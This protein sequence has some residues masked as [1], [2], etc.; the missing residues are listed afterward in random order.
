MLAVA[1]THA[2]PAYRDYVRE[3]LF[4][5]T[6]HRYAQSWNSHQPPWYFA[7]VIATLWLPTALLLPFAIGPWRRR[8]ARRDARYLLPLA[9]VGLVLL[10][11]SIPDGKRDV[12]IL[13]ALPMLCLALGPLLPGLVRRR[14]VR[15][16][17]FVFAALV[18][19][20]T[21]AA[22]LA[23]A[24]GE[25]AFERRLVAERGLVNG[26]EALAAA[27]VGVGL[28]GTLALAAGRLVHALPALAAT[29][30]SLWIA[31]GI[32]VAPL[33]N[34]AASGR[35][36]MTAVESRLGPGDELAL[37]AWKEQMLFM[38]ARP[39]QTFGFATR[40][41][42]QLARAMAWQA[43]K[44]ASRW[45][46]VQEAALTDCIDRRQSVSVGLANRRQWWLVPAAA[47][48]DPHC[49]IVG[50]ES[51]NEADGQDD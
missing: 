2:D 32:V 5:Q 11:F 23:I 40:W 41:S 33:A 14:A 16:L 9:W 35:G 26:T 13:P 47:V 7:G 39:A 4:Q 30:A 18:A 42:E 3:I 50:I 29:L 15:V 25:P 48:P 10:F 36:V 43:E 44:P 27:L 46:L 38:A 51:Q 31:V 6:A 21:L 28:V 22:G 17:A 8:L 19:L 45:L 37:V 34:D 1:L 24:L 49:R 20:V 12:Y